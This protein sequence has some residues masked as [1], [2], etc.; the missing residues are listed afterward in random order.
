MT[1]LIIGAAALVVMLILWVKSS[2]DE[3]LDRLTIESEGRDT[4]LAKKIMEQR[5]HLDDELTRALTKSETAFQLA[6]QASVA[7]RDKNKPPH[8]RVSFDS[9][10]FRMRK[11]KSKRS[12][13]SPPKLKPGNA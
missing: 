4:S 13:D 3:R 7:A 2:L 1:I 9:I 12:P 11:A 6:H 5:K 8:Y 10:K